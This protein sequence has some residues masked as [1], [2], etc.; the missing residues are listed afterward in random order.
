MTNPVEHKRLIIRRLTRIQTLAKQKR[1]EEIQNL[2]RK[3]YV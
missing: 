1:F 2:L 3:E